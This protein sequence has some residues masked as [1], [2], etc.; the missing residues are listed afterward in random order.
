MVLT[1]NFI[2]LTILLLHKHVASNP[3]SITSAQKNLR[4]RRPASESP[5]QCTLFS[6]HYMS[7][8]VEPE[9]ESSFRCV[10][11]DGRS[12]TIINV[13]EEFSNTEKFESGKTQVSVVA[14]GT[15]K[16]V[17]DLEADIVSRYDVIDMATGSGMIVTDISSRR[18]KSSFSRDRDFSIL[19][20]RVSD[21]YHH[22]PNATVAQIS[23]SIFGTAGAPLNLVRVISFDFSFT[24]WF[25]LLEYHF[26]YFVSYY[27]PRC[28]ILL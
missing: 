1:I 21:T 24:L 19:V 18:T 5:T 27:F 26:F 14:S 3:V 15:G 6:I 9:L 7:L 12:K 2:T 23:D 11:D 17:S 10:T 13:P 4:G 16:R 20:V 8:S 25:V 22:S 28:L